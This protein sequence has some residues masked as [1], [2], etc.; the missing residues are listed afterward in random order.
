MTT[1]DKDHGDYIR[2]SIYPSLYKGLDIFLMCSYTRGSF[3]SKYTATS[4]W[5][6]NPRYSHV[7]VIWPDQG[8]PLQIVWA[9]LGSHKP[10]QKH[11]FFVWVYGHLTW[12][13]PKLG[14]GVPILRSLIS[15]PGL[16]SEGPKAA[17]TRHMQNESPRRRLSAREE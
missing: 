7:A 2:A 17:S 1:R 8:P 5:G 3:Y 12:G 9:V 10:Q 14:L 11:P 16:Q 15:F 4:R 13:S 6:P